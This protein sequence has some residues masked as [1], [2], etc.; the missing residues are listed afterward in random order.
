MSSIS[1]PAIMTSIKVDRSNIMFL[2][3]LH[4]VEQG[5]PLLMFALSLETFF[6]W[7]AFGF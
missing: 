3:S 7:H 4:Q 2:F 5:L 6:I 1:I